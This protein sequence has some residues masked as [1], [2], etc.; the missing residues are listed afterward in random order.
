MD[1]NRSISK[2]GPVQNSLDKCVDLHKKTGPRCFWAFGPSY[3]KRKRYEWS[4]AY[5]FSSLP[6]PSLNR[7]SFVDLSQSRSLHVRSIIYVQSLTL[8]LAFRLSN[9]N[10][11]GLYSRQ[12]HA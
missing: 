1:T 3:Q 10:S 9:I 2:T 12:H 4:Y 8:T 11:Q 7:S 6:L 5:R